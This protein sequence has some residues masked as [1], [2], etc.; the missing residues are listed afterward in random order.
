MNGLKPCPFCGCEKVHS[1]MDA[2]TGEVN[3]ICC[4]RCKAV[5]RWP[6]K[7]KKHETFGENLLNWTERWNRRGG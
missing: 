3:G 5:V 6:I 2:F 1:L 4:T 7:M